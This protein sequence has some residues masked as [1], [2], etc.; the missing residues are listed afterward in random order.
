MKAILA[1][2]LKYRVYVH[3]LGCVGSTTIINSNRRLLDVLHIMSSKRSKSPSAYRKACDLC[4]KP[5]DVLVRC[6]IDESASWRFVCTGKCWKDVSGGVIDGSEEKPFYVYGGMWKNKHA[7]TSAKKPKSKNQTIKDW[8]KS[9]SQ[10]IT[11]D[12]VKHD[13]KVWICRR[14]HDTT[15]KSIPGHGYRYWKEDGSSPPHT[16]DSI[17]NSTDSLRET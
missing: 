1:D 9:Q 17:V 5:K 2:L 12:H 4:Q 14:S 8:S 3:N 6:Q 7:G 15:D 13:G 11:H 10:Y 16:V